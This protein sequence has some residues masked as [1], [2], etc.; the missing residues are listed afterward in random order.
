MGM[1]LGVG[2]DISGVGRI[3]S[4]GAPWFR[5]GSAYANSIKALWRLDEASGARADSVGTSHLADNNT[6]TSNTGIVYPLAAEF[7]IANSENLSAATS[8]ILNIGK[9]DASFAIWFRP[10]AVNVTSTIASKWNTT[11]LREWQLAQVNADVTFQVSP[12]GTSS[13]NGAVTVSG[14]LA[15][16]TWCCAMWRYDSTGNFIGLSVNSAAFSSAA[17]S[18]VNGIFPTG[19]AAFRIAAQSTSGGS[20]FFG[21]RIG[22]CAFG[23]GY[24]PTQADSA[25]FYNLMRPDGVNAITF[26]GYGGE[27][28]WSADGTEFVYDRRRASDNTY[29]IF[30]ANS[31]GSGETCIS[32]PG[33]SGLTTTAKHNGFPAWHPG[34]QY[35]VVQREIDSHADSTAGGTVADLTEPGRGW[36]NDVWVCKSDGSQWWNLTNYDGFGNDGVLN[37]RFNH[38]G[39]KLLWAHRINGTQGGTAP[40]ATWELK[41]ADFAVTNGTPALSNITTMTPGSLLFYETQGFS[42]D[43]TK[44]IFTANNGSNAY[45]MDIYTCDLDG[46]NLTNL[47]NSSTQWDE[48]AAWAHHADKIAFMSSRPYSTYNPTAPTWFSTLMSE[49]MVMDADGGNKRQLTHFN[50]PGFAEYSSE[51]SVATVFS[52]N[53]QGTKLLCS[54][55]KLGANYDTIAGRELWVVSFNGVYA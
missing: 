35:I 48:H 46:S 23:K 29:Q 49:A 32:D 17:F 2:V 13:G 24:L 8:S 27:G 31:D 52:W 43:D 53:P 5:N 37:P 1:G 7:V 16:N 50:T 18:S 55:L 45:A 34:G 25:F 11:G 9:T 19:S 3:A 21:G 4:A 14:V 20:V 40:F 42:L 54:R 22:P 6:V 12:D 38:A 30:T 36:W 10:A 26:V 33:G 39:T 47:T 51:H 41:L 15:A 28:D 44:L